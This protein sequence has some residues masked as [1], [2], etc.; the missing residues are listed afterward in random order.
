[1]IYARIGSVLY[2]LWGLLHLEAVYEEFAL[3]ATL[4]PGLAKGKLNQGA[5]D[6]LFFAAASILIA[7]LL[8]WKNDRRGYWTN[9]LLV[10]YADIGFIIFVLI[11]GYVAVFPGIL[12]PVFWISGAIFSTLGI[13]SAAARG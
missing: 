10:S 12:G 1:V 7:I 6:L 5:W 3:A 2:V 13:R 11:P 8:N 9:L 4:G